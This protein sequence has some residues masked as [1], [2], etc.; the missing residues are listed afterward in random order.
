MHS[1]PDDDYGDYRWLEN[2]GPLDSMTNLKHLV[3][4]LPSQ[5]QYISEEEKDML[6]LELKV[7]C[8]SLWAVTLPSIETASMYATIGAR[9]VLWRTAIRR[10]EDKYERFPFYYHSSAMDDEGSGQRAVL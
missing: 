3:Y 9:E 8:D 1:D 7:R 6:V 10:S 2:H 4:I 5:T